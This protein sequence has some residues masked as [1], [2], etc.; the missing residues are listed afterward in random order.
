VN[1][2]STRREVSDVIG[3]WVQQGGMLYMSGGAATRDGFYE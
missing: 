2:W 3:Q 1:D